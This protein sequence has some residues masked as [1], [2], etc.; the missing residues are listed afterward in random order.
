M[1]YV[2]INLT[3]QANTQD[4]QYSDLNLSFLSCDTP[5]PDNL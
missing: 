1:K 4:Y 5:D 3:G 2:Y